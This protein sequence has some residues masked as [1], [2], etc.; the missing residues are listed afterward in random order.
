MSESDSTHPNVRTL[1]AIYSDLARI[2][3]YIA[4]DM[5][6]H[7]AVHGTDPGDAVCV[8]RETVV[9]HEQALVDMT[10]G[11]LVM[12][13]QHVVANDYFGA[14]L[15]IL[16]SADPAIA[17]PFCGLWRF[18]N[19]LVLEHWENAYDAGELVAALARRRPEP[20]STVN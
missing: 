1:R 19:G 2:G 8:G 16:R 10:G 6:L 20:A 9:K 5:V 3:D 15:G 4:D 14:V 17:M 13:V 7:K 12:D 18:A 11:T